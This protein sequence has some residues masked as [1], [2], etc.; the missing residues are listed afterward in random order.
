MRGRGRGRKNKKEIGHQG[1]IGGTNY[2]SDGLMIS[3]Y[4]HGINGNIR[5]GVAH[6]IG[7]GDLW[8]GLNKNGHLM[9]KRGMPIKMEG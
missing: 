1:T 9:G 5:K 2:E 3:L 7:I 8:M 4:I 6:R